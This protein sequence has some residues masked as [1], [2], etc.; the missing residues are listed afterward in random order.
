MQRDVEYFIEAH[1]DGREKLRLH[2][3]E[4]YLSFNNDGGCYAFNDW[5][6]SAGKSAYEAWCEANLENLWQSY[7]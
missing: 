6:T 3:H 7:G 4:F 1:E 5:W 2:E